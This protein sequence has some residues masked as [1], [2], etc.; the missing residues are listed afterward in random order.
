MTRRFEALKE[1]LDSRVDQYN[2]PD[3]I[4]EDPV[5]VPHQYSAQ[6][7]IEITAFWT[8][9]LSWGQRKTIIQKSEELFALMDDAPADFILNHTDEELKRFEG[10]VHR[11]FQ[12]MDTLYFVHFL[13]SHYERYDSLE[14]AFDLPTEIPERSLK[15]RLTAFH[16]YFFNPDWAPKRTRKHVASPATGSSCKRLN[17]FLRWMVRK[18]DRGV[19]F[20]I[21][22]CID[23]SELMI[24][25]DVHVHRVA[26]S[27]N[28]LTRKQSDWKSVEELTSNLREFDPNDPVKYD[29]AL[30]GIGVLDR[31][32]IFE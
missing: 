23:Q 20:G 14:T 10:W 32:L 16:E 8:A 4:A 12:P 19:D 27:L 6:T 5:S 26:T 13:R 1:L 21:W 31:D 18:D 25:L 9:M 29:Y 3:F 22:N 24:P 2:T 15:T 28:L 17:M 7:D 11:T 30:F